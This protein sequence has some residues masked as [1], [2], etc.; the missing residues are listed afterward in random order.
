M[1]KLFKIF[2]C[3]LVILNVFILSCFAET[4]SSD[5]PSYC[6]NSG[7]AW[8]EVDTQQGSAVFVVARNYISDVFS[9]YGRS[10]YNIMNCTS[11]TVSGTIYFK[12]NTNYYG[13]PKELQCRFT[14]MGTL[15]VYEPYLSNY[16]YVNY[17]WTSLPTTK[18]LNTNIGFVDNIGDR[19]NNDFIYSLSEKMQIIVICLLIAILLYFLLGRSWHA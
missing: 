8:A 1:K 9:F 12:N 11:E 15:E 19:Q 3:C 18:I 16:N 6:V 10:G 7:G 5:V 2:I 17:R 4:Y 13:N 14:A